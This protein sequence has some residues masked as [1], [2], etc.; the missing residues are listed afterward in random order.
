MS[1]VNMKLNP[2]SIMIAKAIPAITFVTAV[3]YN[4][5]AQAFVLPSTAETISTN[6]DLNMYNAIIP[7]GETLIIAVGAN[8]NA[9]TAN[10]GYRI[11]ETTPG[12]L[13]GIY[14]NSG[15]GINANTGGNVTFNGDLII[16]SGV[17]TTNS[18]GLITSASPS[19]DS[20]SAILADG[21]NSSVLLGKGATITSYGSS[22]SAVIASNGGDVALK[23]NATIQSDG[24]SLWAH[25]TG[26]ITLDNNVSTVSTSGS[27]I[28]V[29]T[30]AIVSVTGGSMSTQGI[31]ANAV[32][33]DGTNSHVKLTGVSLETKGQ[34][35]NALVISN[36]GTIDVINGSVNT[37]ADDLTST[38]AL[39]NNSGAVKSG[40]LNVSQS[41][42]STGGTHGI[43]AEEGSW[44]VNLDN[45]STLSAAQNAIYL[46][47]ATGP[48]VVN[49]SATNQSVINGNLMVDP[50]NVASRLQMTMDQSTLTGMAEGNIDLTANN[51]SRW[52]MTESSQINQLALLNSSVHF[53]AP[54]ANR[55]K[56]LTINN[57]SGNGTFYINTE[58]NEG[59]ANTHSDL[60][61][62]TGNA[63]GNHLLNINIT[64]NNRTQTVDDG[65]KVVQI[66]GSSLNTKL[67]ALDNE[68]SI[69]AF[70]YYLFEGSKDGADTNDW[71]L[72]NEAPPVVT[73]PVTPPVTPD[74]P[75]GTTPESDGSSGSGSN[76]T[77]P[78]PKPAPAPTPY[79]KE[80]P[81]YIAG[82]YVNMLYGYQTVGTL[83]ERMGD[84]Q[85]FARGYD[86]KTWG[87]Y[88]GQ[89]LESKAGRFNYDIDIMFAQFG[90]DLYQSETAAGTLITSGATVTLGRTQT[91]TR[92]KGR[93]YVGDSIHTGGITTNAYSLGGYYTRY[94]QDGGY[95]D[96]VTQ[97]TYYDNHYNSR[98]DADQK[99][100]G[101]ILSLEGGK[102]YGVTDNWKIEPQGQIVYQLL[103]AEDFS[104]KISNIYGDSHN[105]GLARAGVRFFR[106]QVE[107]KENEIF[108]PYLTLDAVS[109]LTKA[110]SVNVGG[111]NVRA[112]F[113][114]SWWQG[115][116][117]ITANAA[118]NTSFYLDVKYLKS[119]EGDLDGYSAHLGVQ[120][121]F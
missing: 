117:G 8:H 42:L 26:K 70:D 22:S 120:G 33:V 109:S 99:S 6:I 28:D 55:Y 14:T 115:G 98:Y 71:Y 118:K 82:P 75:T 51:A 66:D 61:H 48:S 78:L 92:D 45:S 62:V 84:T 32:N 34:G 88:G 103:K 56:V 18:N 24:I 65:I 1:F 49:F 104:D 46:S 68:V 64:T 81:G 23:G 91:D 100:Y 39:F 121:R 113:D 107:D 30:G 74:P 41:N 54:V 13:S 52:N 40:T 47:G 31:D 96:A 10:N 11:Y 80:V 83:H 21:L 89:H 97:F 3:G 116:A 50:A 90:R 15:Y 79:R 5:I 9:L 86:N 27:V 106:D 17:T 77:N 19:G 114:S 111:T 73:P 60:I 102:P 36:N 59:G 57:L 7:S 20:G 12:T 119:F 16:T 101:L 112:D 69:G 63:S 94:A 87:R 67:F 2:L 43:Y 72:R 58:L 53:A 110:P 85:Q 93:A 38:V 76:V 105:T 44:T 95:I 108:K 25:D 4:S 37:K 29:Q 35:S